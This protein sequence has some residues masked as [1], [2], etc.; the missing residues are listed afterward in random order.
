MTIA[1]IKKLLKRNYRLLSKLQRHIPDFALKEKIKC[2]YYNFVFSKGVWRLSYKEGL[3]FL[4]VDKVSVKFCHNPFSDMISLVG[5]LRYWP[6]NKQG[7][8]IDIGAFMGVFAVCAAKMLGDQ[9]KVL[10]FE[11]IPYS[12]EILAKNIAINGLNNVIILNSALWHKKETL[13]FDISNY[14]TG[15]VVDSPSDKTIQVQGNRLDDIVDGLRLDGP[16][17]LVKMDIEGAEIKALCG[18]ER[19]ISRWKPMFIIASYHVV[20][21]ATTSKRVEDFLVKR[22]YEVKTVFPEHPITVGTYKR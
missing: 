1:F 8:V 18:C 4:E 9:G 6:S 17:N 10:A 16:I 15:H 13:K 3:Y 12:A 19:I 7:I 5:Y 14:H 11:P 22:G 20:N 2:I 21:G